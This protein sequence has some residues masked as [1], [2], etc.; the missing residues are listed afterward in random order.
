M[1]QAGEEIC[2]ELP[3]SLEVEGGRG[4][5]CSGKRLKVVAWWNCV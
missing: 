2:R 3:E 5:Q 4:K 1:G